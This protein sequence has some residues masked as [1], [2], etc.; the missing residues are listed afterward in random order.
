MFSLRF[1]AFRFFLTARFTQ[2]AKNAKD[3]SGS[4]PGETTKMF[5][6]AANR[7]KQST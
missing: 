3:S 6:R 2:D 1:K 4:G 5:R 7:K